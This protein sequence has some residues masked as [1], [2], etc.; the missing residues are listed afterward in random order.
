MF[1]EDGMT[2]IRLPTVVDPRYIPGTPLA[3]EQAGDGIELDT[4][5]VPDASRISPPRLA[6]GAKANCELSIAVE[7][8]KGF[9]DSDLSIGDLCCSQHAITTSL[10]GDC[11]EVSLA[12]D[13]ERLDR[14]FV[15][16]WRLNPGQNSARQVNSSLMIYADDDGEAFGM[17]TL[18][19]P[20]RET[21]S[22]WLEHC[23]SG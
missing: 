7:I 10:A 17:L 19:P 3:R 16:R 18:L 20:K 2:E 5:A 13:D 9:V 8:T 11:V 6:P 21:W 4:N 23:L 12:R 22:I 1:Y 15:L 14:D